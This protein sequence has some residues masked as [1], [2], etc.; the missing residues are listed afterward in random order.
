[1]DTEALMDEVKMNYKKTMNKI[2]F[3]NN[4]L[5]MKTPFEIQDILDYKR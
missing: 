3:Q 4:I 2:I 1:M 5:K